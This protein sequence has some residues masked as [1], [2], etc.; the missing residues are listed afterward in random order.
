M[1]E[2]TLSYELEIL[3]ISKMEAEMSRLTIAT[4]KM[5]QEMTLLEKEMKKGVA[6]PEQIARHVQLTRELD[7]NK[8]ALQDVKK[9]LDIGG[10]GTQWTKFGDTIKS[11]LKDLVSTGAIL[12][13]IATAWGKVKEAIM[14]TT[15]GINWMN[16]AA[17]VSRQL[18]YDIVKSGSLMPKFENLKNAADAAKMLNQIRKDDRIELVEI[19]RKEK[20]IS[21]LRFQAVDKTKS[22]T[23]RLGLLNKAME[24]TNELMDY[25]ILDR[26]EELLAINKLLSK[27]PDD[28]K[29]LE[30]RA[31]L[32]ANIIN[33]NK[34]RTE[35]TRRMES[36]ITGFEQEAIKASQDRVNALVEGYQKDAEEFKKAEEAKAIIRQAIAQSER[37]MAELGL[38]QE[39]SQGSFTEQA[40]AATDAAL[41]SE[42]AYLDTKEIMEKEAWDRGM[43]L[44][45][46]NYDKQ[47]AAAKQNA[48][49]INVI[50]LAKLDQKR[51]IRAMEMSILAGGIQGLSQIFGKS[52]AL[53]IAAMSVEK[54]Q[55]IPQIMS[56]IALANAR[57]IARF[58]MTG[59]MPWVAINTT[60]GALAIGGV[61]AST[62]KAAGE[63]GKYT[64]GG[65]ITEGVPINTGTKDNLLIAVHKDE[66]VLNPYQIA[67]LG[68]SGAMRRAR[69][70]G[71]E[72]GGAASAQSPNAGMDNN[73]DML[74]NRMNQIEV[75]LNVNKLNSSQ[76]ELAVIN[77]TSRI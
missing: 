57:M 59:G 34:E 19:A 23:E 64:T 33:L 66:A 67:A 13:L 49:E 77:Q 45:Y 48:R 53:A 69:V 51:E 63:I 55:A 20:E 7:N 42:Q 39:G 44:A 10:Y 50:D 25:Q 36:Q 43:A 1:A 30:R 46:E 17:E 54:A 4:K 31:Q 70:P 75:V 12:G 40:Q 22:D 9:N 35:G 60:L 73:F 72:N 41:E 76:N 58:P 71:F 18:F 52:K 74:S 27:R 28:E 56:N 6:S 3:G 47:K 14:S 32:I 26:K 38:L 37:E 8:K 61:I 68:G 24:K 5:T 21:E 15:T 16:Q 11:S 62:V 65:R 2:K 29:L